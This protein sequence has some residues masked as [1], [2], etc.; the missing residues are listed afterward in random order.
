MRQMLR[1][2]SLILAV[3][4]PLLLPAAANTEGKLTD[5]IRISSKILG[6]DLQ[7]RIYLP[8]GATAEDRLPLLFVTDGQ[9]YLEPGNMKQVLDQEIM[10]RRIKPVMAVFVD[11]RNPD[12]L[13][14]NR[15]RDQF[16]CNIEYANFFA[17]ELIPEIS[18]NWPA[19]YRREDKVIMGLSF[20]GVNAACFGLMLNKNFSGIAMQSPANDQHLKLLRDLYKKEDHLPLKIFMSIGTKKDNTAAGRRFK[21]TLQAKGYDLTYIEVEEGHNWKNWGPLID[22]VLWTFFGTAND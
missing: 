1:D 16:F 20:G 21:Q 9:W 11:S 5:N 19:S 3:C 15:R 22:D 2:I 18:Y 8:E 13:M 6:Y 17:R 7:Y 12:D 4:L 10:S 14:E